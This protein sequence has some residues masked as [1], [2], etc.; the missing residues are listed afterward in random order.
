MKDVV[1]EREKNTLMDGL[2]PAPCTLGKDLRGGNAICMGR[3]GYMINKLGT[4]LASRPRRAAVIVL[5]L[6]VVLV[7]V[8]AG[9][10]LQWL[11]I[12]REPYP[13]QGTMLSLV[14]G[15]VVWNQVGSSVV[16]VDDASI[17]FNYSGMKY[18]FQLSYDGGSMRFA[19]PFGNQSLLSVGFTATMHEPITQG[20]FVNASMDITDSTGDGSFNTGDR[21]VFEIE[22][23]SEGTI[24]T[25][26]LYS[27]HDLGMS[28]SYELSFAIH[29]GEFYAWSSDYLNTELPW[30]D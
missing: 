3:D 16:I 30:W 17:P 21:I 29:D 4:Y 18:A 7:I 10:A 12:G 2:H 14:N 24:Y 9:W 6:M 13:S 25:V 26:G 8:L 1:S 20:T 22:P 5:V 28:T 27:L 15:T 11:H 23:L 19:G